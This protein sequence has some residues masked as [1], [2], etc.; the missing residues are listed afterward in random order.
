MA[1]NITESTYRN[2]VDILLEEFDWPQMS[3]TTGYEDT[4]WEGTPPGPVHSFY[5]KMRERN[6]CVH[7]GNIGRVLY[8]VTIH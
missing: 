5:L 6:R 8:F 1:A 4:Q 3:A 2:L 7:R